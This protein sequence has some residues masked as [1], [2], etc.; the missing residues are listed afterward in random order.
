[1]KQFINNASILSIT[2]SDSVG[3]SGIQ[4][5][6]KTISALGG[7]AAT[8]ITSVTVQN[9]YGI[10]EVFDLPAEI[11][12]KQIETIMED[13]R[14]NSV[15][16]GLLRNCQTIKTIS[17]LI[18]KYEPKYVVFEPG[19]VSTHGSILTDKDLLS[20][21]RKDIFP[22]SSLVSLKF[23]AATYITG[24]EIATVDDAV[25]IAKELLKDGSKAILL[26]GGRFGDHALTDI[27]LEKGKDKPT[28]YTTLG[29]ID[30][31]SHGA[32]GVF[33][34]AIA[35]YFSQGLN[36]Q[37]AVKQA[38]EYVNRLLIYS[39]DS[40]FGHGSPLLNH[41]EAKDVT[42]HILELYN[43]F[44]KEIVQHFKSNN[45]VSFYADK[46]NVTTRYLAQITKKVA[47]KSPKEIIK[48]QLIREIEIQLS[49]SSK[50]IQEIAYEY[51]FTSQAQFTK[52][53]KQMNGSSPTQYRNKFSKSR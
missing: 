33:S 11:I 46:L 1:M 17:R 3:G 25:N 36:L 8:A 45:D 18:D 51:G 7:Y 34:A 48:E 21:L 47:G 12:G 10:H 32:S 20:D 35:T 31:N 53:F 6:I 14:P 22:R 52:F 44:M 50:N 4:A 37:D 2:G 9:T 19:I 43:A 13:L 28:F 40:S 30:R 5:D 42:P 38:R 27:L 23:E 41:A 15:K 49:S 16:V 39:L 26:Q 24:K 29:F